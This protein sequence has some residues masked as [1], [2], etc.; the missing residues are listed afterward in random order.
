MKKFHWYLL[1]WQS[2]DGYIITAYSCF[3]VPKVSLADIK[4]IAS[5]LHLKKRQQ[6]SGVHYM[7]EMTKSEFTNDVYCED[8]SDI[9]GCQDA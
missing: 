5:S 3:N 6:L 2:N 8:V 4:K 7:G 1:T 9:D